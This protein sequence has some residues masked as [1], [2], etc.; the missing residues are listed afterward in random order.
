VRL[1]SY[2]EP[3]QVQLSLTG[4]APS[5]VLG[6][7]AALFH[8]DPATELEVR[9][10]LERRE[11]LGSTGIGR[12]IAVPHGRTSAVA[13]L[14]VAFGRHV[15]GLDFGA[16]DNA[17]VHHFFVLVAPPVE[18]ANEYLPVL[19][20]IAR[21]AKEPDIPELLRAASTP[22]DFLRILEEREV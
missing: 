4:Q 19:G 11:A 21:L 12:G 16:I 5:E 22:E 9:Q 15:S 3:A 6:E 18:T 20:R 2:I 1:S 8:F 17:P 13:R 14:R 7:L 10:L